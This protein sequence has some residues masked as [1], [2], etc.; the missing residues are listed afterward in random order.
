MALRL[1]HSAKSLFL[2]EFLA[3]FGVVDP[4]YVQCLGRHSTTRMRSPPLSLASVESMRC[5][6]YPNGESDACL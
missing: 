1:A 6:R 3:A 5:G 2:T 4:L